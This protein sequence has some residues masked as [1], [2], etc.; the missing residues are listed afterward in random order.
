[1]VTGTISFEN[2][3][4]YLQADVYPLLPFYEHMLT[5]YMLLALLWGFWMLKQRSNKVAVHNSI[6]LLGLVTLVECALVY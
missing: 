2:S 4:G 3:Y 1:V 6:S 5:V